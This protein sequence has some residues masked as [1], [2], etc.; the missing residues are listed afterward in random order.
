VPTLAPGIDVVV[1]NSLLVH[2]VLRQDSHS[3]AI[4]GVTGSGDLVQAQH[5]GAV[6]S[7]STPQDDM[8]PQ[9]FAQANVDRERD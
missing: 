9:R 8:I 2:A 7:S 6:G 4:L 5:A 3:S 1:K